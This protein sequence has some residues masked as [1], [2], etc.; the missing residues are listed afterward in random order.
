MN[1]TREQMI[2]IAEKCGA[3]VPRKYSCDDDYIFFDTKTLAAYTAEVQRRT[4]IEAARRA[5]TG[6]M[7]SHLRRMADE[8]EG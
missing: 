3:A 2:E 5:G 4:L 8:I 6:E 7:D 1:L